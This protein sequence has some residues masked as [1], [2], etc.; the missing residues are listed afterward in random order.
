MKSN[1]NFIIHGIPTSGKTLFLKRIGLKALS[2]KTIKQNAVFY[3]DLQNHTENG[4]K[5]KSLIEK[6]F[7]ELTKGEDFKEEEF[8]KVII[9]IAW[10]KL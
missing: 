9:M 10:F 6:Q 5:I 1:K 4:L 3:F 8:N 7:S 2:E